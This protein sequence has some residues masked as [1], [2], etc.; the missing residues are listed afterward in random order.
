MFTLSTTSNHSCCTSTAFMFKVCCSKNFQKCWISEFSNTKKYTLTDF[1]SGL[2]YCPIQSS[3][4]QAFYQSLLTLYIWIVSVIPWLPSL[5]G[6]VH[7]F[8][9][10]FIIFKKLC[11]ATFKKNKW[12]IFLKRKKMATFLLQCTEIGI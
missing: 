10:F 7:C 9:D 6:M 2:H 3:S 4:N 11:N 1:G 5:W 12:K 8:I